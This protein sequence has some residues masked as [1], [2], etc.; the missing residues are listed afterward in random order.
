[1]ETKKW[2]CTVCGQIFEGAEPPVPCPVCGAGA[3]AFVQIGQA[4]PTR[5][6]CT[7]CGQIFEGAQPPVPC[8]V[9]GVGADL[10]EEYTEE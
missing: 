7:V 8:P 5:W 4:A 6:K 1:M 3:D 2:R 9:C 10:I